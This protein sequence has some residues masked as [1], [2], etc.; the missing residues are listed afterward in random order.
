MPI[1][2]RY[3][4]YDILSNTI[5][6]DLPFTDVSFGETLNNAGSF[7]GNLSMFGIDDLNRDVL[8]V[9]KCGILV[10]A[11]GEIIWNGIIWTVSADASAQRVRVGAE[12]TWSY[13]S[14]RMIRAS[15]AERYIDEEFPRIGLV[16]PAY[17][18]LDPF[19]IA[20]EVVKY[21]QSETIFGGNA[22]IH[23]ETQNTTSG[24][25]IETYEIPSDSYA[26]ASSVVE[27]V[28][29]MWDKGFDFRIIARWQG[30]KLVKTFVTGYPHLGGRTGHVFE[31][32]KN[33]ITINETINGKELAT[34]VVGTGE[35]S[36]Q[37]QLVTF[38]SEPGSTY[39][40][41]DVTK[42][43]PR[44]EDEMPLAWLTIAAARRRRVP[45]A[46]PSITTNDT[47]FPD[48]TK[49]I[50]GDEVYVKVDYGFIQI[51]G[52]YRILGYDCS[53]GNDGNTNIRLDLV[54]TELFDE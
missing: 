1:K 29:G 40:V 18:G 41:I 46:N 38:Y 26:S 45:L 35:G 51:S 10:E 6:A 31:L 42:H 47:L 7:N 21:V 36:G 27:D 9:V 53:P 24:V 52:Y 8:E 15:T 48:F 54:P 4:T 28:S 33:I 20:Q 16:G 17:D 3:L 44:I 12:G 14:H 30:G 11:D 22:N 2:Y 50:P 32:G 39:P 49:I 25:T 13:F 5:L 23:V 37:N 34:M 43:W 19:T